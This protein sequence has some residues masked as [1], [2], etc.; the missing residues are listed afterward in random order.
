MNDPQLE[1]ANLSHHYGDLSRNGLSIDTI[2]ISLDKGE[3]LGLL[4]PSG[5]GKT[6]LLRLIA[7]F[8]SPCEGEIRFHKQIISSVSY[9]LPPEKRGIG[10]VFQ[11]FAL[12][13]HLN[14]WSN[15]C[16]G[17]KNN[18]YKDRAD[19]L[20]DLTG[21]REF[22]NRFPHELS[23][24]Q[25]QR[26]GLARALAPGTS[27]VL[28]DEPFSSLDVEVRHRL[29]NELS[30]ILRSCSASAILVTHDPQEALGICDRVAVMRD[31]DIH[32]CSKPVEILTNPQ[33]P[34]IGKFVSQNNLIDVT[35]DSSS[36][37]YVTPFGT[38]LFKPHLLKSSPTVLMVDEDS[39]E[40]E[41]SSLGDYYIKGREF[42]NTNW[43]LLVECK[44]RTFRVSVPLDAEFEI[45]DSCTLS[46]SAGKY[47]YLYPGCISCILRPKN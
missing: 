12:F 34:F 8:E 10:M 16:F 32:Q 15:I 30:S 1:I 44:S 35:K 41:R 24:G 40:I 3:L 47:G 37:S 17:L 46:F 22:R 9:V 5:C 19:W 20:L 27:L 38:V 36:S 11:D 29:R 43:I 18:Q 31:G 33:T 45:G 2:N 39:F 25:R 7:G 13:P 23:G 42:N 6:T 21:L 4:G 26:L 28:L 14:V